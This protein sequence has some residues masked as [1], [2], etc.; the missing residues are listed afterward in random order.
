MPEFP[1]PLQAA[2]TERYRLERELGQGG[3]ATVY[4][5]TDPKHQRQVA[6]KVLKPELAAVLGSERFLREITLTAGL[7]HPHILPL[8]DSGSAG[9]AGTPHP[10]LYYTMPYVAGESLRDRLTRDTQLP[11]EEAL[12]IIREVA[13]ALEYA[14]REGIIHRDIKPE[15]ILLENGH[16]MVAD[17]GIA[18][19]VTA[20][21]GKKLTETGISIGTPG[22]MSPEQ[23]TAEKEIDGRS[24]IYSLGCVL[25]EMLVG[26]VPYTGPSA[27]AILARKLSEPLPSIT[28][29]REA[30]TAGLEAAIRKALARTAA[31]RFQSV[32]EFRAALE[33]DALAAY[34]LPAPAASMPAPASRRVPA[35]ALAALAVVSL[36]AIAVWRARLQQAAVLNPKLIAAMP[37]RATTGDSA[38]RVFAGQ[39]PARW[40]TMVTGQYGPLA[41][42]YGVVERKWRERGGTLET[43]L[44]EEEERGIARELGAGLLVRGVVS[45]SAD[46]LTIAAS[47]ERVADGHVVVPVQTVTGPQTRM[48]RLMDSLTVLLLAPTFGTE[49]SDI[50]RLS[51][52]PSRAVQAYLAGLQAGGQGSASFGKAGQQLEQALGADSS[53]VEAALWKYAFGEMDGDAAR[54]AWAHRDQLSPRDVA[55]LKALAP[56]LDGASHGM[57]DQIEAWEVATRDWN[58]GWVDYGQGLLGDFALSVP[59]WRVRATRVLAHTEYGGYPGALRW[60][61][62][63]LNRD[64]ACIRRCL[65]SIIAHADSQ[66]T[67]A[68]QRWRVALYFG[69]TAA[70]QRNFQPT[71]EK[72]IQARPAWAHYLMFALQDGRG[73]ADADRAADAAVSGGYDLDYQPALNFG[74]RGVLL[75]W[76]RARGRHT[77]FL[78]LL[79]SPFY[80]LR[81]VLLLGEPEDSTTPAAVRHFQDWA[82]GTNPNQ[83]RV[84]RATLA[85]WAA[86]H[87]DT[88]G[89]RDTAR[90]IEAESPKSA[91]II[92]VLLAQA[93]HGDLRGALERLDAE[94]RRDPFTEGALDPTTVNLFLA[95]MLPLVG[96]TAAALAAARRRRPVHSMFGFIP[97]DAGFLIDM[98]REEGRLAARMGDTAGAIKAYSHYLALREE[99]DWQPWRAVRDQV[100]RELAVL[101]AEKRG[102]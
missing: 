99:P 5:A 11:V 72:D 38:L 92:E 89:L 51:K 86:V 41:T 69:D 23:T 37:F 82:H 46:T 68:P 80:S 43:G 65:D 98:L 84:G 83:K 66:W 28:V 14:H 25:Y 52:H 95:R 30:V 58:T 6:L 79:G 100:R 90:A 27:Q 3:M 70:A 2:L 76:A 91:G 73:V 18:R 36:V 19:A 22:Y 62:A 64:S 61:L 9:G 47:V 54:Y 29:V 8:L 53:L 42:D 24:D 40:W 101:V 1:E 45:G 31:D 102:R 48:D 93:G 87:G 39:V 88:V 33:P 17:F 34:R 63:F 96:D 59:D 12:R 4:L 67:A 16:A 44:P 57:P 85:L 7:S 26:E 15:N 81:S 97:W 13:D 78:R 75:A 50:P 21:G 77:E 94:I 55:Y 56:G 74:G 20:T 60:E 32:A 10:Y 71:D 49:V 35:I